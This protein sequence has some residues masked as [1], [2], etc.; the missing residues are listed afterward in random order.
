MQLNFRCSSERWSYEATIFLN[1]RWRHLW[2]K[3]NH[4][5]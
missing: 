4:C 2:V 5:T 1:L 3:T